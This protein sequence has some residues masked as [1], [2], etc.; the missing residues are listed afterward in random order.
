KLYLYSFDADEVWQL[1]QTQ[2]SELKL[3]LI[4]LCY[5]EDGEIFGYPFLIRKNEI[6]TIGEFQRRIKE[7]EEWRKK[8]SK[9]AN[10]N[11]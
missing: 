11:T 10:K 1:E 7:Y 9:N 3:P 2:L 8:V 6:I 5:W 4:E